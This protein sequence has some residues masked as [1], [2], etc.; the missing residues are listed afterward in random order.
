MTFSVVVLPLPLGPIRPCTWPGRISRSRSSIACTPPKLSAT[1]SSVKA[2]ALAGAPSRRASRSGRGMIAPSLSRG[3]AILEIQNLGNSAFCRRQ[4]QRARPLFQRPWDLH[5][6]P[7]LFR[8][9]RG[10]DE[11]ILEGVGKHEIEAPH[12]IGPH[13]ALREE[14]VAPLTHELRR[15]LCE[16]LVA[17]Q[18]II[19]GIHEINGV[20]I[21][22]H[23]A[24]DRVFLRKRAPPAPI[25]LG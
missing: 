14:V 1:C 18:R 21:A 12:L 23:V 10:R 20:P 25:V 15:Y 7:H 3:A 2:P 5:E 4:W 19:V 6:L 13:R 17:Q 22:L 16:L 8:R 9:E 24:S 11:L